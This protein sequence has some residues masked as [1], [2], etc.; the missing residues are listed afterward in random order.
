MTAPNLP[1]VVRLAQYLSG[2]LHNF[3]QAIDN[4][5]WFANIHIYQCPLPW[6]VFDGVGLYIEQAYDLSLNRPYR[7]RALHLFEE[8]GQL[9]I[10][11]Y[12]LRDPD[13]YIG[14][15][16]D[17]GMLRSLT[18]S[19]IE[20]LPGCLS[21]V[22]ATDTGFKGESIGKG[23]R[24]VRKGRET[25]SF[26]QFEVTETKF[27]SLDRGLDPETDDVVWGSNMGPF[28]FDKKESFAHLIPTGADWVAPELPNS[29]KDTV[30]NTG[31][32]VISI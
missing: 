23:C 14:A 5:V 6:S 16:R 26:I 27:Q 13:A 3:Q 30:V 22:E 4:P 2:H 17:L 19:D 12:S 31:D 18:A 9:R 10:Q 11:N 29:E 28:Q 32:R 24:V 8:D 7:Q 15:G 25:Y 21:G 1:P 20:I